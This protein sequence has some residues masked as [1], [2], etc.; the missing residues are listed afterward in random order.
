VNGREP[1]VRF[2][3]EELSVKPNFDQMDPKRTGSMLAAMIFGQ[4]QMV[5]LLLELGFEPIDPSKTYCADRLE[6][7]D[8]PLG[9]WPTIRVNRMLDGA[10]GATKEIWAHSPG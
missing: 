2:L 5:H 3:T 10:T 9:P 4:P 1:V 8:Y 7:G 6:S